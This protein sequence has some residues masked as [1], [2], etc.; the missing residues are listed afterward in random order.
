MKCLMCGCEEKEILTKLCSNMKIMGENFPEG[1]AF[2]VTCK[3]CGFVYDD[4]LA[5]QQDFNN[6][7][8]S[9]NSQAID[10]FEAYGRKDTIEYFNTILTHCKRFIDKDSMI[11]DIGGGL[12]EFGVFLKEEGYKNVYVSDVTQRWVDVINQKG[13]KG[14]LSDTTDFDDSL[15]G[16]FDLIVIGNTL[17]HFIDFDKAMLAM[18]ELLTP[19]GVIYIECPD[20][21]KYVECSVPYTMF[22]YEHVFHLTEPTFKNLAKV[23]GFN[24]LELGDVVKTQRTPCIY[25]IYQNGAKKSAPEFETATKEAI[26]EYIEYSKAKLRPVIEQF[27]KTQ[28]KLALWGI[29]ASTALL[30]NDTFDNCNVYKLIDRNPARQGIKYKIADKIHVIEDPT[31]IKD[32]DATIVVLPFWYKDSI[33]HQIKEMGFKNKVQA[34]GEQKQLVEK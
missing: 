24:L 4:L 34:I 12:A 29:G 2:I 13:L 7:Y 19:S 22:T 10:Y 17:E 8:C 20:S 25:G 30:L 15:K 33:I 23:F 21:K 1:E 11:M 28:E 26:L 16:K 14:V 31:E 27:E 5:T 3:N 9:G 32:I 6:Y 18:R